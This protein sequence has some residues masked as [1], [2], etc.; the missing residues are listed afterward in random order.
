[1]DYT[2][3]PSFYNEEEYFDRYLGR[4]SY[5][6]NLQ[7]VTNK[8]INLISPKN[9]LELGSALGTTTVS[10]AKEYPNIQFDGYDIREDI[11]NT[12]KVM[13]PDYANVN[14][15]T[16]D[17]C[18]IV[19][20]PLNYDLIFLLYSFH[21]IPDPLNKKIEFLKDCYSN[22]KNG[23]YLLIL[24]TFL[25]ENVETLSKD[26]NI[27]NLWEQR[28][29]EGYASTF[30]ESLRELNDKG[31]FFAKHV[32]NTSLKEEKEAGKH[33]FDRNDEYLV[34]MSWLIYN[35]K[36]CGFEVVISEP[37]NCIEEKAILIRKPIL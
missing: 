16:G 35:V 28:S 13:N 14:F 6:L 19:K 18:N 34:K 37:I 7:K 17:M 31:I 30:W 29:L 5:Y 25:P 32:A 15:F 33:V 4:T 10:L 9:V 24:E 20:Q 3:T 27:I 11:V 8:L 2:N 1:M 12:A 26:S 23:S 22:M 36:H 21:H